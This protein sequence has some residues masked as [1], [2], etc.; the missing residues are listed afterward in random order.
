[1]VPSMRRPDMTLGSSRR[2]AAGAIGSSSTKVSRE[3]AP[4][5]R[6]LASDSDGRVMAT[7]RTSSFRM[8]SSSTFPKILYVKWLTLVRRACFGGTDSA[9]PTASCKSDMSARNTM[10]TRN[11]PA[12]TKEV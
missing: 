5:A 6:F 11:I 8:L 3:S 7:A 12:A 2:V 10:R 9:P 1:M 4:R